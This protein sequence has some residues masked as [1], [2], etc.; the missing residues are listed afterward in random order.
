M[1]NIKR[2]DS[3]R[4]H[5][6]AAENMALRTVAFQKDKVLNVQINFRDRLEKPST[7][8]AEDEDLPSQ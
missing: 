2:I 5:K 4:E 1:S 7:G 3:C 8:P 6:Y